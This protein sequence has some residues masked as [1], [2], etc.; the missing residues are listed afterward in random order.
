MNLTAL[1]AG[2][3]SAWAG[4]ALWQYPRYAG[5]KLACVD[6][7]KPVHP[8]P[9]EAKSLEGS[10]LAR[11]VQRL[12]SWVDRLL[13]VSESS[14]SSRL[15]WNEAN[16]ED[17]LPRIFSPQWQSQLAQIFKK[18]LEAETG[19]SLA[20]MLTD[21]ENWSRCL[22]E[23]LSDPGM[24]MNSPLHVFC[25]SYVKRWLQE[26]PLEHL[27]SQLRVDRGILISAVSASAP[28]R[29]P[30]TRDD[31][32]VDTSVIAV[33]KELWGIISPF[34]DP[35]D[36]HRFVVMDWQDPYTVAVVRIV[37]GLS[38]GWRGYPGLRDQGGQ[39]PDA[40]G[41]PCLMQTTDPAG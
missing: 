39:T 6:L 33:G 25:V 21:P 1:I 9:L 19:K 4:L 18:E 14:Q 22:V 27:L 41:K 40:N 15:Q 37:L 8:A 7:K 32:E 28:P 10:R 24:E 3:V 30:Q 36:P 16:L 23:G 31:P 35:D 12:R 26:K 17:L 11:Q 13:A 34:T 5:I 2:L 29:W 20:Q 38:R